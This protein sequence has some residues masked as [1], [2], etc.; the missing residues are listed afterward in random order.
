MRTQFVLVAA[1][2]VLAGCGTVQKPARSEPGT[3]ERACEDAVD[4]DPKVKNYW[5]SSGGSN[6]N[7]LNFNEDYKAARDAAMFECLRVRNGRPKGG[8][9]KIMK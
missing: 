8:V 2:T 4:A 9:E 7:P 1:F 3:V 6:A 5:A